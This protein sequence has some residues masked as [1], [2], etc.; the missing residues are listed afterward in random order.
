MKNKRYLPQDQI[1]N[2]VRIAIIEAAR[3]SGLPTCGG[4][5]CG[6]TGL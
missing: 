1:S 2:R 6:I 5:K 3:S 4:A